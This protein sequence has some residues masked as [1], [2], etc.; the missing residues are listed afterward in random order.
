VGVGSGAASY[1]TT[2]ENFNDGWKATLN[3]DELDP[4]RLDGWQQGWRIPAGEGG[5]VKLSYEPSVTYE[6]G[7]IGGGAGVLALA[8]LVLF[9]RRS[10]NP[11]GPSPVPPAPGLVL[12][13]VALTLVGA[14]IAGFFALL[15][16]VLAL[17]AWRRHALL[18]PIAFLTLAGAG[19]AAATGAGTPVAEDAGA[20]GP[21]AQLLALIGLFAA[22]V[23][24]REAA[25]EPRGAAPPGP[26]GP[27]G[28][29]GPL[30]PYVPSGTYVPSE[31]SGPYVPTGGVPPVPPPGPQ[32]PTEPLPRRQRGE[33][34]G[35][36]APGIPTPAEAPEA[37]PSGE[38]PPFSEAP[39][40]QETPPKYASGPTVSAR[41]PAS[42][43][44]E[45]DPPT[46]RFPVR[47][48]KFKATRPEETKDTQEPED[49]R[50]PQDRPPKEGK[51]ETGKGETA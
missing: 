31:P 26:P 11:D 8:G 14:V 33:S 15:V 39:P 24:V 48:P 47:K 41:G 16:P 35:P 44:R 3:G 20:F 42:A 38:A 51:K 4:V 12:G 17:L 21:A 10:P 1:L 9:R 7:L 29:S 43:Q 34:Y 22:L 6:A 32:A 25:A 30:G 13:V 18:V 2:Y 37:P 5:T 46:V 40:S 19:I 45:P 50:E 36:G 49:T 28:S 27:S 23:S